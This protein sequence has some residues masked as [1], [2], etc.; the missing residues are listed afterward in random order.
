M[1]PSRANTTWSAI[2][3]ATNQVVGSP[4]PVGSLAAGDRDRP[5]P[6]ADRR[7]HLLDGPGS[8]RQ[9]SFDATA[10]R[11]ADGTIGRYEWNFGDGSGRSQWR[12]DSAAHLQ[13]S[14][15]ISRD[16]D[17]DRQRGLLDLDPVH[18][19]DR[20]LQRVATASQTAVRLG[21]ISGGP[22]QV[23][24]AR[25]AQAA[26]GS[27][28][29]RY[30]EAQGQG[31]DEDDEGKGQGRALDGRLAEAKAAIRRQARDRPQGAVRE[32]LTIMGSARR[33]LRRLPLIPAT[34]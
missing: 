3:T 7:L 21:R 20:L 31:D 13:P 34:G 4:I 15:Q 12:A 27:S 25:E 5:R 23:P 33:L 17:P 32:R 14:R 22:R 6:G 26:A 24:E 30:E 18:R 16:P 19:A 1:S 28:W 8:R 9:S 2:D 10:S 29:L 11:D